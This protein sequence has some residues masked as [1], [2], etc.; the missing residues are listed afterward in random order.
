LRR[1]AP[2]QMDDPFLALRAQ[3]QID[4]GK[5]RRSDKTKVVLCFD[6]GYAKSCAKIASL[7]VANNLRAVFAVM[8]GLVEWEDAKLGTWE[9]WNDLQSNGHWIHPHSHDHVP[10]GKLSFDEARA[11]ATTCLESFS[12]N[13]KDFDSA[14]TCFHFPHNDGSNTALNEWLL[15]KVAGIRM[16]PQGKRYNGYNALELVGQGIFYCTTHP[17]FALP[18]A[19]IEQARRDRPYAWIIAL[20]GVDGEGWGSISLD[21]LGKLLEGLL[22]CDEFDCLNRV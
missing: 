16:T 8:S 17:K 19:Q 20:H 22:T 11:R 3:A 12:A 18:A 6:D 14:L 13:L 10:F 5:A 4:A 1:L 7:F 2:D 21:E 9:M 15:G